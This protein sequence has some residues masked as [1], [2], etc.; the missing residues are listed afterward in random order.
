MA[1][2]ANEPTIKRTLLDRD[3]PKNRAA[4]H[5]VVNKCHATHCFFTFSK[6][7]QPLDIVCRSIRFIEELSYNKNPLNRPAQICSE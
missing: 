7:Q 5:A 4:T 1:M 6:V 2:I 3:I